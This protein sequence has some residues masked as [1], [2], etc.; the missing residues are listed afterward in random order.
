MSP[1]HTVLSSRSGQFAAC[2]FWVALL[3]RYILTCLT[4]TSPSLYVSSWY[5]Q[6]CLH[7]SFLENVLLQLKGKLEAEKNGGLETVIIACR[8]PM[9]YPK[10]NW[11]NWGFYSK[12]AMHT[13]EV[14]IWKSE[15]STT[16]IL[17][18]IE[19]FVLTTISF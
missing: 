16:C 10:L 19:F 8:F 2:K 14:S 7:T 5:F 17:L 15:H 11:P 12:N 3:F 4:N 9:Y 1:L 13:A 6:V 18:S